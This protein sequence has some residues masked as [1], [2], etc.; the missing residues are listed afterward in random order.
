[1]FLRVMCF[2]GTRCPLDGRSKDNIYNILSKINTM[3]GQQLIF[4]YG[5]HGYAKFCLKIMQ[6]EFQRMKF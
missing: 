2:E 5:F 6:N 1:M 3:F 4:V